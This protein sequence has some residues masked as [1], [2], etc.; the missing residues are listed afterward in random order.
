[1]YGLGRK[2][3]MYLYVY[4]TGEVPGDTSVALCDTFLVNVLQL[5]GGAEMGT[6]KVRLQVLWQWSRKFS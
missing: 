5:S 4:R 6:D 2:A 3:A 1:M